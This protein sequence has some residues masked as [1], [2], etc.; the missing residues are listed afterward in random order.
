MRGKEKG[1]DVV[2]MVGRDATPQDGGE[3][4]E[5]ELV[6]QG[7]MRRS[8]AQCLCA[9][10]PSHSGAHRLRGVQDVCLLPLAVS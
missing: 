1:V 9:S 2:I 4:K 5:S 3:S 7:R 8:I 6:G 10:I